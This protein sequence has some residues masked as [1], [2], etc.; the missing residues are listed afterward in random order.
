MAIIATITTYM[1]AGI[2][3]S[4]ATEAESLVKKQTYTL[5]ITQTVAW[6]IPGF[7]LALI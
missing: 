5:L 2:Y 7:C 4:K 1:K 6:I 3:Q